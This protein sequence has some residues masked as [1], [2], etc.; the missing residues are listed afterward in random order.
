MKNVPQSKTMWILVI[1]PSGIF[2]VDRACK[3]MHKANKTDEEVIIFGTK[4]MCWPTVHLMYV[5]ISIMY[6]I[7][8]LSN[9]LATHQRGSPPLPH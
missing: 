7:I 6:D 2:I 8:V 5:F 9:L 1:F 3:I 4:S